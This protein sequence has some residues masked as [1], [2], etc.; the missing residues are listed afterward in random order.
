MTRQTELTLSC[1][2]SQIIITCVPTYGPLFRSFSANL[3]SYRTRRR[4]QSYK[5]GSQTGKSH[6]SGNKSISA[7]N[8]RSQNWGYDAD[9]TD[10]LNDQTV[11]TTIMTMKH[12]SSRSH[13]GSE[14]HILPM[15][16]ERGSDLS[17]EAMQIH[18]TTEVKVETRRGP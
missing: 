1:L 5:L 2:R 12:Q 10:R 15:D 17:M 3:S 14:E 16:A 7:S 9:D 18:T 4:D 13:S 11:H 6:Q 8:V